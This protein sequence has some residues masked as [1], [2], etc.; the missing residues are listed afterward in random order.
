LVFQAETQERHGYLSAS[1]LTREFDHVYRYVI[2]S[3][4]WLFHRLVT[5]EFGRTLGRAFR[6]RRSSHGDPQELAASQI[7]KWTERRTKFTV[8]QDLPAPSVV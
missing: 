1:G 5:D 4:G 3:D 6:W 7:K 8:H 2:D